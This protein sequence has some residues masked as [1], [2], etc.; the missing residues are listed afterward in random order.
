LLPDLPTKRDRI[1]EVAEDDETVDAHENEH[2]KTVILANTHIFTSKCDIEE[3]ENLY[4][5]LQNIRE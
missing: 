4:E 2:E 1:S 3:I 5:I